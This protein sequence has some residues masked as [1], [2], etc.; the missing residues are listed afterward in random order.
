MN[1]ARLK[2]LGLLFLILLTLVWAGCV[3]PGIESRLRV[4]EARQD[5]ILKILSGMQ[6]KHEFM[7]TRM[8]WRPPP[9]TTPKV[10]PIGNAYTRGPENA[11]LTIV[12]FSDMECPY[13]SQVA[14]VLDSISKS[15][16]NEIRLVFKHFPLSFHQKAREVAAASIAAGKQGK[17]FEFRFKV[18]A[19]YNQLS[20]TLYD[21]IATDLGL[22]ME[23]FKKERVL[24]SEINSILDADMELGR[25]IGVEG[26]PTLFVN[27]KLASNRSF[28]YFA[29]LLGH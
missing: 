14:P 28:E 1:K 20:E 9:D 26:T 6:E 27:G 24:N 13:C 25:K 21:S 29:K 12:E 10:I 22:N 4:I 23:Q 11:K 17:F 19:N 15:F 8:G 2:T 18:A 16:P 3:S 5:S 7:A